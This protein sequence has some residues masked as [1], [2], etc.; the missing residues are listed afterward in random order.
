MFWLILHQQT[1]GGIHRANLQDAEILEA[2]LR[3]QMPLLLTIQNVQYF[4]KEVA[5][6]S[7]NKLIWDKVLLAAA[8]WL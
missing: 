6:L 7:L 8:A 5:N 4:S 2:V 1:F 3:F